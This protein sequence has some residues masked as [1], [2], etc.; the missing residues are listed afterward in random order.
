MKKAALLG[1]VPALAISSLAATPTL[2]GTVGPDFTITLTKGGSA[3]HTLPAGRYR[4]K[5]AD[6]SDQHNFHLKGPGVNKKTSVGGTGTVTWKVAVKKGK[7]TFVCD[8]HPQM[9]RGH[10]TVK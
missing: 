9:M 5:V 8:A 7:Y 4:I 3:V 1:V 6:K 10:F 2:K